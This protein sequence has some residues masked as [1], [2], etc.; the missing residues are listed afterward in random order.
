MVS[1]QI[2]TL[3]TEFYMSV[4]FCCWYL[5]TDD[6]PN[7]EVTSLLTSKS[8]FGKSMHLESCNMKCQYALQC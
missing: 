5:V 8:T 7:K 6:V 2:N 1:K 4:Q 3:A